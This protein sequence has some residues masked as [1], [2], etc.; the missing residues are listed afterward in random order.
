MFRFLIYIY[1]KKCTKRK[2]YPDIPM[3]SC[4]HTHRN[5]LINE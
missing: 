5:K 1:I 3:Y 4:V 2:T